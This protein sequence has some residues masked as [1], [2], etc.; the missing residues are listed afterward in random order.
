MAD[1]SVFFHPDCTVGSGIAPDHAIRLADWRLL[2]VTAGRE[3]NPAL[4]TDA[5]YHAGTRLASFF[6]LPADRWEFFDNFL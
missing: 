5:L 2:P 3:L 1:C 4:K 6:S